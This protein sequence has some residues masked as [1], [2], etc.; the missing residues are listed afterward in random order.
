LALTRGYL[1]RTETGRSPLSATATLSILRRHWLL[2]RH[3]MRGWR[4]L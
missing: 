1:D 3:A 2:L 4:P